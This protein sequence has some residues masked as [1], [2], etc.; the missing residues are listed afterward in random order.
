MAYNNYFPATYQPMYPQ[1]IQQY[2]NPTPAPVPQNPN[3]GIIW[4]QGENAA[5][6]YLV[7]AG[8]SVVLMDSEAPFFYIKSADQSG[9]P[10]MKKYR[11][12]EVTETSQAIPQQQTVEYVTRDEF[13]KRIAELSAP[14]KSAPARK[15]TKVDG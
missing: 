7:A 10:S 1:Q 11:F 4:I 3:S 14:R 5:K 12:E 6:S 8:N 9:M 2:Q 15:E 13:E